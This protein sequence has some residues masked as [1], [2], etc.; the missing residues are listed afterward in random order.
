MSIEVSLPIC[1]FKHENPW[2]DRW[3]TWSTV[4]RVFA[5]VYR[6]SWK[7]LT[8]AHADMRED[9]KEITS[10]WALEIELENLWE[11][12]FI[13][14]WKQLK[15]LKSYT[16]TL[17]RLSFTRGEFWV[18]KWFEW[19]K[20]P[21]EIIDYVDDMRDILDMCKII[22]GSWVIW[23]KLSDAQRNTFTH[24]W[25]KIQEFL[26]SEYR[27]LIHKVSDRIDIKIIY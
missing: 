24:C 9:Q 20:V 25:I 13:Q 19:I 21:S 14:K 17:M 16:D 1:W 15:S 7:A 26:K 10:F 4:D 8:C 12:L 22:S 23:N 2:H 18:I 6:N 3:D 5:C 11:P 27:S